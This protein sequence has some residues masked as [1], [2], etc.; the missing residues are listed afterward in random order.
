MGTRRWR[1]GGNVAVARDQFLKWAEDSNSEWY[2]VHHTCLKGLGDQA[3]KPKTG[4]N[5]CADMNFEYKRTLDT[6]R[7]L[8]PLRTG[9][10]ETGPMEVTK[11]STVLG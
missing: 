3:L 6:F 10:S 8:D 9:I 11:P 5:V 1:K 7:Y 4:K 2:W